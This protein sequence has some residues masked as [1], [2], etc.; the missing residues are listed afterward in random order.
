VIIFAVCLPELTVKS[1]I[2]IMWHRLMRY[3]YLTTLCTF[4]IFWL[5]ILLTHADLLPFL[6]SLTPL[7]LLLPAEVANRFNIGHQDRHHTL[8]IKLLRFLQLC[9]VPR[10]ILFQTIY[11]YRCSRER[12]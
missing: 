4:N 2:L 6:F 3:F 5:F 12:A 7:N 1:W 11:L 10:L 9:R 8:A